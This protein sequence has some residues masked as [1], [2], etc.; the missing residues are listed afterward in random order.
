MKKLLFFV[1]SGCAFLSTEAQDLPGLRSGNY[2]G[3]HGVFA[4]PASIA[5]S[6]YRFD[7]N[8]FSMNVLAANDQASFSLKNMSS[9]FKGDS[10]RNQVFGKDAGPASGMFQMDFRGP[11][12]MFNVARN[13][14]ALTTRAR[15]FANIV[16]IDGKLFDK[17]SDDFSNDPELPY[18][19]SSKENMRLSV[20]AWTEF[21]LS[22]GRVITQ[23]GPH[24]LKGGVTLKYLAGAGNAYVNVDQFNGTIDKDILMQ[25]AYLKNTTGRI[26]TGFGGIQ[27]S[28]FDASNMLEMNSAGIGTDIGFVYEYRPGGS[29]LNSKAYKLKFG[30]AVL[31]LGRI[32]YEKDMQRSGAY[33]MSITDNERLYFSEFNNLDV[34]DYNAFFSARPQYFTPVSGNNDEEYS[35]S[36]P[37]TLQV[38]ADYHIKTGFYVNLGGQFSLSNNSIKGYNNRSYTGFTLTPRYEKKRFGFYLPISYNELTRLNAGASLRVGPM[39][40]G[41]GS[42]VSALMG[43][44][45]Q[46]DIYFGFRVSGLK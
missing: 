35:V 1:L 7:I 26:A 39:F 45:K 23:Q 30:V 11:S 10:I 46:A 32:K 29:M 17:L 43:K 44:S 4:N 25:D 40:I 5:D 15:V 31:D 9:S 41:S 12:V 2:A 36:L 8:L 18:T 27:F 13:S 22:Y 16:D 37:T 14:F 33:D 21:G 6:R 34:D 42:I 20:N 28:E 19:V 38:D 24:Y 3:V